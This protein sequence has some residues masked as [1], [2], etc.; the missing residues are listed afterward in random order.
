MFLFLIIFLEYLNFPGLGAA[1]IMP[2]AGIVVAKSGINFFVALGVSVLAGVLASYI[3]YIISYYFGNPILSRIYKRF[4]K[5]RDSIEKTYKYIERYG[6]KGVLVT[7]LVPVGRTLIPFV[8]GTFRMN[9]LNFTVYS[10]IGI[11]IWNAIFIY[12]GYAFGY[13]F[14]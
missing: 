6:N 14:I 2:A 11:A 13:F 3:L 5:T 7:R 8:A 12:A 1:V 9:I 4:P 10:T